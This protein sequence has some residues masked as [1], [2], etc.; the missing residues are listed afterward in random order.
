M[1][2][3]KQNCAF[4]LPFYLNYVQFYFYVLSFIGTVYVLVLNLFWA[5][6]YYLELPITQRYKVEQ[7][8]PWPWHD[9]PKFQRKLW[10][11]IGVLFFNLFGMNVFCH[12]MHFHFCMDWKMFVT[13]DPNKIPTMD[14]IVK[15]I[16]VFAIME[17]L[18]FYTFHR[19]FHIKSPWMP[20]YQM[21][22]KTHHEFTQTITVAFAYCHPIEYIVCNWFT[23]YS[24]VFLLSW[25]YGRDK[26]HLLTTILW[27][28]LRIAESMD[29]H[30][31]FMFPRPVQVL[32]GNYMALNPIFGTEPNYHVYHHSKNIGNFGTFFTVWDTVF[33]S[34]NEFYQSEIEL[35]KQNKSGQKLK[36]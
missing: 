21:F 12:L 17:D 5:I 35:E 31:G 27:F 15:Q 19:L 13:F 33:G 2:K 8:K 4:E 6:I 3:V 9:D 16:V 25:L 36:N 30:S 22:H 10:K 26:V 24:G 32:L 23:P 34:N 7:N 29:G 18:T 28:N 20:L 1:E 14:K 11:A